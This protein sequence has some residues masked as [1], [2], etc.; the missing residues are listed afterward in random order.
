MS[1][2]PS[3][4]GREKI[5]GKVVSVTLVACKELKW[6]RTEIERQIE[7][8]KNKSNRSFSKLNCTRLADISL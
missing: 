2:T 8:G 3:V 6:K 5:S 4:E 7:N 1:V